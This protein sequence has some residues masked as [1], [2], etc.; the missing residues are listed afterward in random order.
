[1]LSDASFIIPRV[2]C[3]DILIYHYVLKTVVTINT[4]CFKI[5]QSDGYDVL[6]HHGELCIVVSVTSLCARHVSKHTK[7][8]P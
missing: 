2:K 6:T 7:A 5:N 4:I 8:Y 1:M 3:A